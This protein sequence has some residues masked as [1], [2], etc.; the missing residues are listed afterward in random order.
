MYLDNISRYI[1]TGSIFHEDEKIYRK[2]C[3]APFLLTLFAGLTPG[4]ILKGFW[5]FM[6]LAM[7]LVSLA[8]GISVLVLAS[9]LLTVKEALRL[10][11]I[12]IGAWVFDLSML[13]LMLFTML[14]GFTPWVLLINLPVVLIPLLAGMNIRKALKKPDYNPKET[15][16][17]NRKTSFF[18]YVILGR[19]FAAI[20]RNV[21][22]SVAIIVA[23]LCFSIVN[24][25]MSV[26]FLSLQKL[27]YMKKFKINL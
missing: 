18:F 25:A 19:R 22:Q 12:I 10:D 27:Y 4:G 13:E 16:K 1:S 20:F 26:G 17:S 14:K 23:L 6:S 7:V 21:D 15:A 11:V 24:G 2:T 9:D 8:C 3:F 5:P